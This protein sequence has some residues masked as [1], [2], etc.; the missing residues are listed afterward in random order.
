MSLNAKT[1]VFCK[2]QVTGVFSDFSQLKQRNKIKNKYEYC[3]LV[4]LVELEI[5]DSYKKLYWDYVSFVSY[6]YVFEYR[7]P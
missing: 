6:H 5:R 4:D 3:D 1:P 2:L 7:S